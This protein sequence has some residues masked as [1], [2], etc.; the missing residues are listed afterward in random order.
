MDSHIEKYVDDTHSGDHRLSLVKI[1]VAAGAP[2]KQPNVRC[3][4]VLYKAVSIG[5]I[6]MVKL[7][8]EMD[9]ANIKCGEESILGLNNVF[10]LAVIKDFNEIAKILYRA[11]MK[12]DVSILGIVDSSGCT[13]MMRA[14]TTGN[15][16]IVE[17]LLYADQ[18]PPLKALCDALMYN[19]VDIAKLLLNLGPYTELMIKHKCIH[20]TTAVIRAAQFGH[21]EMLKTLIEMGAS[22]DDR[23]TSNDTAL[24]LAVF[25]K[26]VQCVQL[27]IKADLIRIAN[28]QPSLVTMKNKNNDTAFAL[29]CSGGNIILVKLLLKSLKICDSDMIN[30]GFKYVVTKGYTE[31]VKLLLDAGA[32]REIDGYLHLAVTFGHADMVRAFIAAG[33][34]ISFVSGKDTTLIA[35]AR[36][37][38][39]EIV[40]LL[41]KIDEANAK[42]IVHMRDEKGLSAFTIANNYRYTHIVELIALSIL[43]TR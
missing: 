33:A 6:E 2:L 27:L 7:L 34:S 15:T 39:V 43:S 37:G 11:I 5:Q 1:L 9:A 13:A 31:I 32:R 20:D 26:H 23:T 17:L 10:S 3:L 16:E 29:A 19:R 28:G 25:N 4:D 12:Y 35:A 24:T 41:L 38:Y 14:L 36:K 42:R 40:K 22:L 18:K 30:E 21:A 8:V